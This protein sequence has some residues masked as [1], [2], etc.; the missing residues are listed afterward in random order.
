MHS[1]ALVESRL[2]I[3]RLSV[4]LIDVLLA[5]FGWPDCLSVRTEGMTGSGGRESIGIQEPLLTV[6]LK[7]TAASGTG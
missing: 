6:G 1:C 3:G 7:Q 2:S 5:R 4:P